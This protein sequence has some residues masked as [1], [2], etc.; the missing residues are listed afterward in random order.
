MSYPKNMA[1]VYGMMINS[2]ANNTM[3]SIILSNNMIF[4]NMHRLRFQCNY[5]QDIYGSMVK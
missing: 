3:T 4:A 1:D 5:C 2:L